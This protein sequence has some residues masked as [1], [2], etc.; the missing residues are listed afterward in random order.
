VA[1]E[2]GGAEERATRTACEPPPLPG[3][4]QAM[5]SRR[6]PVGLLVLLLVSP[7]GAGQRPD[8]RPAWNRPVEPF[9]IVGNVHY[10]GAAGVSAFLVTTPAGSILLDGG[11]P[12]S[13]AVIA[14]NVAKLGHRMTDVKYLLN[15]HAHFDHAGGLAELK[16]LS[17]AS[18]V[19][20]AKDGEAIK[21]GGRDMPSAAVDRIVKDGEAVELGGTTFVA[22]VTPGHTKG[23]TT[24][25]TTATEGGRT[26]DVVFHCSTS[27]VDA[28]VGN[29]SYPEIV[30]DYER[31][32]ATL[33]TV[34]SDV[35]LAPHPMF[36][37][38]DAKRKRMTAGGP[39]PFVDPGELQRFNDQS[40]RQFRAELAKQS[41]R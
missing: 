30:S 6:V 18:L 17:N 28:L 37:G 38:L 24:W 40:E 39:N 20:S 19:A 5:R 21:A 36:F 41:G 2:R 16:R 22:R 29:A 8:E 34:K 10:V 23:C 33:R 32:F 15:S 27:V 3:T 13:A 4:L 7:I 26:Y 14:A 1:L 25:T 11:L 31:T 35:F 9:T 12:E